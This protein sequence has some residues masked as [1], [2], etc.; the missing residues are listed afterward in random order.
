MVAP[1]IPASLTALSW[2]KIDVPDQ[3]RQHEMPVADGELCY[4]VMLY[5]PPKR[6]RWR[7]R[8]ADAIPPMHRGKKTIYF[9]TRN[10]A[11]VLKDCREFNQRQLERM[12]PGRSVGLWAVAVELVA[13]FDETAKPVDLLAKRGGPN[14]D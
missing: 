10:L 12:K 14:H 13:P 8:T 1:I 7:P 5:K 11:F 6:S 3:R 2:T 4:A 9:A